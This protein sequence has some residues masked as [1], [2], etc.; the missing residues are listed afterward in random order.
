[1]GKLKNISLFLLVSLLSFSVSAFEGVIT[2]KETKRNVSM[3]KKMFVKGDMVR[4]ETY[5]PGSETELKGV[6]IVD[7]AKGTVTALIP[8]RELYFE[9]QPKEGGHD[10]E[11]TGKATGKTSNIL[12]YDCKEFVATS[13]AGNSVTFQIA[14][15]DFAF[16]SKLIHT[17]GK[18]DASDVFFE[19][20][21]QKDAMPLKTEQ[22]NSAGTVMFT[23]EAKKIEK[24]ELEDS[25]FQIPEGYSM[26]EK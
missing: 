6:K 5:K 7:M 8:S 14:A 13:A 10:K 16:F 12:G 15:G 23:R 3:T 22:K 25:L 9:V 20:L 21:D 11:V 17:M 24:T 18:A 26:W 4:I 19:K 2:W 1:M